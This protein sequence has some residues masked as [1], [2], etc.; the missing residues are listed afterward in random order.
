MKEGLS[1]PGVLFAFAIL[2]FIWGVIVMTKSI[3]GGLGLF[4]I[5]AIFAMGGVR[6]S[7]PPE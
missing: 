3:A 5:A 6:R 2:N 4:V 7:K 1:Y